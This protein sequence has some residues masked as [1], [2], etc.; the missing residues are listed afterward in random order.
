MTF[1]NLKESILLLVQSTQL[2]PMPSGLNILCQDKL[3]F[4]GAPPVQVIFEQ[5]RI[6]SMA[7]LCYRMAKWDLIQIQHSPQS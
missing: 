3:K 4:S 2:C 1:G 7:L 5:L 6:G